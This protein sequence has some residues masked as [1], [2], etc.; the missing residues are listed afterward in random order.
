MKKKKRRRSWKKLTKKKNK[1]KLL[2]IH[3]CCNKTSFTKILREKNQHIVEQKE[4]KNHI[5]TETLEREILYF[6][7]RNNKQTNKNN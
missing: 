6:P 1:K 5:Y 3:G 2:L 4:K 7:S